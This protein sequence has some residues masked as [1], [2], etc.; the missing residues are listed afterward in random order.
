MSGVV[1]FG[2]YTV[3]EFTRKPLRPGGTN[4]GVDSNS[5]SGSQATTPDECGRY[6]GSIS[7]SV[8]VFV[9]LSLSLS[10][11]FGPL[12]GCTLYGYEI[13][14]FFKNRKTAILGVW[15]APDTLAKGGGRSPT[16]WKGLRGP[17]GGPHLKVIDFRT[18]KNSN[19]PPKVQPRLLFECF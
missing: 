11:Y 7:V 17:R 14:L 6:W 8:S 18:L 4:F 15:A 10:L 5:V 9:S 19:F 2:P 13:S 1:S 12:R 3:Y 16:F